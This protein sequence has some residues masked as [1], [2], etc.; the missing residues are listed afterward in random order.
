VC[1]II[2]IVV[3]VSCVVCWFLLSTYTTN[4]KW[5]TLAHQHTHRAD[6]IEKNIKT[7]PSDVSERPKST[8]KSNSDAKESDK[9]S[10]KK[11]GKKT[12]QANDDNNNNND[13]DDDDDNDDDKKSTSITRDDYRAALASFAHFKRAAADSFRDLNVALQST[14]AAPLDDLVKSQTTPALVTIL[15]LSLSLS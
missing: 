3:T 2:I 9:K 8:E 1:N 6:A 12:E 4:R 15:V 11:A 13:D 7:W 14:I 5:L 10:S